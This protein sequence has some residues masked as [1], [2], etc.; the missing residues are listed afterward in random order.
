MLLPHLL[1][2]LLLSPLLRLKAIP[3][4]P[5][6]STTQNASGDEVGALFA[7]NRRESLARTES[8]RRGGQRG[9]DEERRR[10]LEERV[11]RHTPS[12]PSVRRRH[13]S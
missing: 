6:S 4:S 10:Q 13:N 3:A 2:L 7:K 5:A 11:E 1:L 8:Y 9:L 12:S